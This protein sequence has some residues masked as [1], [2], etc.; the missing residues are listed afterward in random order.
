MSNP[1]FIHEYTKGEMYD[2]RFQDETNFKSALETLGN[3]FEIQ[4][5]PLRIEPSKNT[6]MFTFLCYYIH[7]LLAR[8]QLNLIYLA[9][10][11][12]LSLNEDE[13][14][15]AFHLHLLNDIHNQLKR[16]KIEIPDLEK[17]KPVAPPSIHDFENKNAD[18]LTGILHS[19]YKYLYQQCGH[20]KSKLEI[21]APILIETETDQSEVKLDPLLTRVD[22]Q[23]AMFSTVSG[24]EVPSIIRKTNLVKQLKNKKINIA[25][26]EDNHKLVFIYKRMQEP[27]FNFLRV[28]TSRNCISRL[29]RSQTNTHAWSNIQDM[30]KTRMM[31]N[32][33]NT[34]KQSS[35]SKISLNELVLNLLNTPRGRFTSCHTTPDDI[36]TRAREYIERIN[37]LDGHAKRAEVDRISAHYQAKFR[38]FWGTDAVIA[39][40]NDNHPALN[41]KKSNTA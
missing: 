24:R 9:I 5:K 21:T 18:T 34:F 14:N 13:M 2:Y 22:I 4:A 26:C 30:I 25:D 17:L 1:R 31:L 11:D 20:Y 27:D 16:F 8:H 29:F 7:V 19:F 6:A 10:K 33:L 35:H 23:I 32:I 40:W 39:A 3:V 36:R 37:S 12:Y 38:R 28:A 41:Q 15:Y